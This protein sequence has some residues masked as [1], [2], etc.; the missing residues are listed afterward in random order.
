MSETLTLER[1]K[2]GPRVVTYGMC[3]CGA[4]SRG[5]VALGRSEPAALLYPSR[6]EG[7]Y[8]CLRTGW[9]VRDCPA[10]EPER[11]EEYRRE[12][13]A[14]DEQLRR[15]AREINP[16][17]VLP[18]HKRKGSARHLAELRRGVREWWAPAPTE[19]ITQE[20]RL[21]VLGEPPAYLLDEEEVARV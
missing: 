19:P 3:L 4:R 11:R 9:N 7:Y 21:L 12:G 20:R 5:E 17:L 13:A 16:S 2:P 6:W 18:Y 8:I 10:A 15:T 1:S 14:A